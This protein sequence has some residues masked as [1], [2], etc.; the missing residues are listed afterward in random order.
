MNDAH[1]HL[2]LIVVVLASP[3]MGLVT[4]L[5]FRYL[6]NRAALH[7]AKNLLAAHLLEL[8]LFQNQIPVVI[9]AYG[10][11]VIATGRYLKVALR[12]LLFTALPIV[13]LLS[14][15]DRYL[16]S[17]P[18][19]AGQNFLVKAKIANPDALD[20]TLLQLPK[21]LKESAPPVHIPSKGMIVWRVQAQQNGNYEANVQLPTG[22]FSKRVVVSRGLARLSPI[23]LRGPWWERIFISAEPALPRD[24]RISSIEVEYPPRTI[25]FAGIAWDWIWLLFVLS[26]AA[27][28]V[29]KTVLGVEI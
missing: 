12:P 7:R 13:L 8:R 20:T 24:A 26:L 1:P 16:G 9:R 19:E 14:Q 15:M 10:L 11:I 23:R 6:S 29:F 2:P 21:G 27:A 4:V 28:F 5:A 18:L 25:A 3:I 22:S 17:R